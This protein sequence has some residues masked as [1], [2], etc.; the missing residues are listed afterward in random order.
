MSLPEPPLPV[1][2]C[3]SVLH[4]SDE[5]LQHCVEHLVSLLGRP[6]LESP[7]FPFDMSDYYREE[8]GGDPVR[9]WFCFTLQDPSGLPEWKLGSIRIE[10][11]FGGEGRRRVNVDPG[12]LDHGKLVLAS[13]KHAPDKIYLSKGIYA[14]TCL[15]YRFGSFHGP[16]HSFAD[17]IDGRFNGF[18]LQA[19][20]LYR[21]LLRE[22]SR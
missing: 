1:L 3:V 4:T 19:K 18:F 9:K 21:K 22:R 2:P 13:C 17:F 12:Y 7:V 11:G 5:D 6:V 10:S 20:S 8:M 14:H 16:D 15:R